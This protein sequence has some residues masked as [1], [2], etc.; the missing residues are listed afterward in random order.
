[1][2]THVAQIDLFFFFHRVVLFCWSQYQNSMINRVARPRNTM[3]TLMYKIFFYKPASSVWTSDAA[4]DSA[5]LDLS[6]FFYNSP[7]FS[8]CVV[9]VSLPAV[10][11]SASFSTAAAAAATTH[12]RTSY[13]MP[14]VFGF[15]V[16][17]RT[18]KGGGKSF[19][20]PYKKKNYI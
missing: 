17:T 2:F 5:V 12:W 15:V 13:S 20:L 8:T 10:R 6:L 11:Y 7:F 14:K 1:M 16:H 19:S 4:S 18:K 9:A 3:L